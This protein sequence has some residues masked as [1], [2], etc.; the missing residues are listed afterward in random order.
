MTLY[1][2]TYP[3]RNM[4]NLRVIKTARGVQDINQAVKDGFYPLLKKADP[5]VRRSE[6]V[7]VVQHK[8]T[9]EIKYTNEFL[10][11]KDNDFYSSYEKVFDYNLA[12]YPR[13]NSPCT[14]YLIPKDIAVNELVWIEDLIEHILESYIS[15]HYLRDLYESKELNKPPMRTSLVR[16]GG[17]K[18][19]W[20]GTDLII[21]YDKKN[22]F[23]ESWVG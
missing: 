1:G 9:G 15:G 20:D 18:A 5:T 4:K 21:Q 16:L 14:A 23:T 11:S 8:Q 13:F 3:S 7:C 12:D 2:S 10:I 22:G 17:C 6:I 19:I